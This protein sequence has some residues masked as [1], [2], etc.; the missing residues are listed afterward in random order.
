MHTYLAKKEAL[1]VK[2]PESC[3]PTTSMHMS[4]DEPN[5]HSCLPVMCNDDG[6]YAL[7]KFCTLTAKSTGCTNIFP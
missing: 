5:T 1:G 7:A 4:S 2:M 3:G 6:K